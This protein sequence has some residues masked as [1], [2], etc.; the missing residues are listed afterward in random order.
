[1]S[2]YPHSPLPASVTLGKCDLKKLGFSIF[3]VAFTAELCTFHEKMGVGAQR[4]SIWLAMT[5][6]TKKQNLSDPFIPF[7]FLT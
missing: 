2:L 1:M 5:M 7:S 4:V 6:M 3:S